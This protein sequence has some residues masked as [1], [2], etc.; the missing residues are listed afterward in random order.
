MHSLAAAGEQ[1]ERSEL[2]EAPLSDK[3]K[4]KQKKVLEKNINGIC[5]AA[6]F[7]LR[8]TCKLTDN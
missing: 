3:R 8:L 1:T 4:Q 2:L 7:L 6:A 5:D